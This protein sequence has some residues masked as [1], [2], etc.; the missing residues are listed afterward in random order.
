MK[1][2]LKQDIRKEAFSE[3]NFTDF[4]ALA[5]ICVLIALCF[6]LFI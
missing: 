5:Y 1:K 2:K 3:F 4:V 6:L